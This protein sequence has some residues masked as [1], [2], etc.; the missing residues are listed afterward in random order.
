MMSTSPCCSTPLGPTGES[1]NPS[2]P[3]TTRVAPS[4]RLTKLLTRIR[5]RSTVDMHQHRV[6]TAH[7]H[8][9]SSRILSR[10]P[11]ARVRARARVRVRLLLRRPPLAPSRRHRLPPPAAPHALCIIRSS[12]VLLAAARW[13]VYCPTTTQQRPRPRPPQLLQRSSNI[14]AERLRR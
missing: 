14:F 13:L 11:R 12:T 4:S 10:C 7:R 3:A 6:L 1:P 9:R 5:I 2:Q 8:R